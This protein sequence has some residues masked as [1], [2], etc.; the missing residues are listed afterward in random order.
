MLA[1]V[2]AL[3]ADVRP[4]HVFTTNPEDGTADHRTTYAVVKEAMEQV[5]AN[6]P[7]Y[8]AQLHSCVVWQ[9]PPDGPLNELWPTHYYGGVPEPHG[10]PP[11]ATERAALGYS[12]DFAPNWDDRE[13]FNVPAAM[14]ASFTDMPLWISRFV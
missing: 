10:A 9:Q 3:I 7:S 8:T 11:D 1:D 13:V 4:D 5:A 12:G 14:M 6:D 2:V